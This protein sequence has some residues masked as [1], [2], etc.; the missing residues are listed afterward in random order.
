MHLSHALLARIASVEEGS[1]SNG[2]WVT[3]RR[4]NG[5]RKVNNRLAL[6]FLCQKSSYVS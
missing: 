3:L 4:L 6:H 5:E 2:K 1:W